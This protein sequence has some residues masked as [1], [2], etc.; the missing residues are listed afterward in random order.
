MGKKHSL[1]TKGLSLSQAQSISNLCNQRASDISAL[2]NNINNVEKK[3]EVNGDTY[4][5][6]V[7]KPVPSDLTDVTKIS[8]GALGD[9]YEGVKR[10]GHFDGVLTVVN[11]LFELVKPTWAIFGEKDFQ[12][13]FLI[14]K[15]AK[16]VEIVSVPT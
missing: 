12:Q 11:R 16:K 4:I 3:L 10:P 7:G 6:T 9:I 15:I 5:E 8:A 13:L 14:K 2:L 1:T